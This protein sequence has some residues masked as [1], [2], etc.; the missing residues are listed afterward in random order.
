MQRYIL[1]YC[2]RILIPI[3]VRMNV[4]GKY[5]MILLTIDKRGAIRYILLYIYIYIVSVL[6]K[7]FKVII[8]LDHYHDY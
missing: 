2:P 4:V 1:Q 8:W 3:T 5:L 7:D 6:F